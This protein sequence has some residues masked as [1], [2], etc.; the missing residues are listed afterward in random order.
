MSEL[1]VM[2]TAVIGGLSTGGVMCAML[3]YL[4]K[5]KVGQ[6]AINLCKA[7]REKVTLGYH[8]E[9]AAERKDIRRVLD[10]DREISDHHHTENKEAVE[11]NRKTIEL[12]WA[13]NR[14][15]QKVIKEGLTSV[16]IKQYGLPENGTSPQEMIKKLNGDDENNE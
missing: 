6:E 9:A 10:R 8:N 3:L 16:I 5:H 2:I 1:A 12:H 13:K 7:E 14:R 11:T 15:N 4:L